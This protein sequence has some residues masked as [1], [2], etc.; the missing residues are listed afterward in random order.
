MNQL[1][2]HIIH[3]HN[4]Q[5]WLHYY[6]V[7]TI[8]T[9]GKTLDTSDTE[10]MVRALKYC[11][12]EGFAGGYKQLPHLAPTYAGFLATLELGPSAY[13]LLD[14]ERLSNFFRKMKKGGRFTMH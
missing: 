14:R 5:P 4:A 3:F 9:L 2:Q 8:K 7:H 12:S 13:S 1:G 10:K 11:F 6:I